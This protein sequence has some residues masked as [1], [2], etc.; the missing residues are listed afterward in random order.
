MTRRFALLFAVTWQLLPVAGDSPADAVILPA[1][2]I[3]LPM[4]CVKIVPPSVSA[5]V[6]TFGRT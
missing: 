6:I 5:A 4:L 3:A 2:S 1:L